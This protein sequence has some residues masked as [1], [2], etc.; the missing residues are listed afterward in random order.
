[1]NTDKK[2][3]LDKIFDWHIVYTE[4]KINIACDA[5]AWCVFP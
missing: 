1:M 4:N 2:V 3:A 5:A